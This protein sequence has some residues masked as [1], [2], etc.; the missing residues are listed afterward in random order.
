MAVA[1]TGAAAG[2]AAG[3]AVAVAGASTPLGRWGRALA[4]AAS[5][6]WAKIA[7][8]LR[9]KVQPD[10][11]PAS[12]GQVMTTAGSLHSSAATTTTATSRE[13]GRLLDEVQAL[14]RLRAH[15][16][17]DSCKVILVL[18]PLGY[19]PDIRTIHV[20]IDYYRGFLLLFGLYGLLL[21]LCCW[22][23]EDDRL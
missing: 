15:N 22:V 13:L 2:A 16:L 1:A 17:M 6:Y 20:H 23:G 21:L 14:P 7:L 8:T 12:H 10:A 3:S 11:S 9:E 18:L 19:R 5:S 4:D